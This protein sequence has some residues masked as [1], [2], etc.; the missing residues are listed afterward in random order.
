M[1]QPALNEKGEQQPV[2]YGIEDAW[3]RMDCEVES[4]KEVPA[5]SFTFILTVKNMEKEVIR[6]NTTTGIL[7]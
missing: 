6:V 2:A 1:L 5:T 4:A 7:N 3:L